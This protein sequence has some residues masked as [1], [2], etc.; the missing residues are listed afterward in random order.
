ML[1]SKQ[2]AV[3]DDELDPRGNRAGVGVQDGKDQRRHVESCP[4]AEPD[5]RS[6]KANTAVAAAANHRSAPSPIRPPAPP[7]A[8][9]TSAAGDSH[10]PPSAIEHRGR[11]VGW[12]RI[13]TRRG[14]R[15]SAQVEPSRRVARQALRL[16]H[17]VSALSGDPPPAGMGWAVVAGSTASGRPRRPERATRTG[18]PQPPPRPVT[19]RETDARQREPGHAPGREIEG[20]RLNGETEETG[21][22]AKEREIEQVG[23]GNMDGQNREDAR[24]EL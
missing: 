2:H 18:P 16:L 9:A 13:G 6:T 20:A 4:S 19:A 15:R 10:A 3:A 17:F 12:R 24:L 14:A 5:A 22:E 11:M 8:P 1:R 7:L 21:S 23:E